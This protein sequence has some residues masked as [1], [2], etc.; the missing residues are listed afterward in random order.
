MTAR[1]ALT[2]SPPHEVDQAIKRLGADLRVARLRRNLTLASVAGHIG[3]GIRAIADA[4]GGKP[5]TGVAVY[6]GLL[7]TYGMVDRLGALA[8]PAT[9]REGL[10]L[11]QMRQR[12]RARTADAPH[13]R[14]S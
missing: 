5:S 7:W 8:D 12:H 9:D 4:E 13:H 3:A 1:N 2:T 10:A 14:R 11:L 6:A